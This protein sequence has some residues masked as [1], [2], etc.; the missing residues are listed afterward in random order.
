MT[1]MTT[2]RESAEQ[3]LAELAAANELG[4]VRI[5]DD[6]IVE[7]ETDW[8]FPYD[9]VAFIERGDISAALAGNIPIRVTKSDGQIS[10]SLPPR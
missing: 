10:L 3:K 4:E 1:S 8:Y 2:A 7:T 6:A 5:V 9:A